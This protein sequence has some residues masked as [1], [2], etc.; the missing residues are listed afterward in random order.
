MIDEKKFIKFLIESDALQFGEF[1]TKSG[2]NSPYFI[3]TGKFRTGEQIKNLG[4]FYAAKILEQMENGKIHKDTNVLFGPAYKGIPLVISTSIALLQKGINMNYCFNRKEAK[5][6]GEGG[7]IVGYEPQKGDKIL[8]L[9]DVITAGTAVREIIPLLNK[10]EADIQGLIV[11]VD[12]MEKYKDDFTAIQALYYDFA[13]NTFPIIKLTHIISSIKEQNDD[14]AGIS[15]HISFEKL[16][17]NMK[18]YM[19]KYCIIP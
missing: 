18:N 8:I 11:S 5:D 10:F 17:E 15:D 13:I 14:V 3:N 7:T 19:K 6:H 12:R 16:E 4:E 9:E 2:R 1:V